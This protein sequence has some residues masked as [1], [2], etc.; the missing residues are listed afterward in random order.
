M[1]I[2]VGGELYGRR[3]MRREDAGAA[4]RLRYGPSRL[5]RKSQNVLVSVG[6]HVCRRR[7]TTPI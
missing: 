4:K 1:L 5:G 3:D 2:R 6:L 7:E